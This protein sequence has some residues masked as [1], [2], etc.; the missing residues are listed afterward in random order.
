VIAAP[1]HASLVYDDDRAYAVEAGGFPRAGLGE[2]HR[3]PG[4]APPSR[5]DVLAAELGADAAD[6]TF[7]DATGA[8][9]P[10]WN[11]YRV[12]LDHLGA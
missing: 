12:L 10:Q 11:A 2:G 1:T 7:V 3:G 6:V 9:E 4:M 8:Y 5:I